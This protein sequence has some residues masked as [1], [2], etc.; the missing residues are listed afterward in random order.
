MAVLV[1]TE[2]GWGRRGSGHVADTPPVTQHFL[3]LSL[4]ALKARLENNFRQSQ[5][6]AVLGTV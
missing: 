2:S 5:F 1:E 3:A 6:S 4:R